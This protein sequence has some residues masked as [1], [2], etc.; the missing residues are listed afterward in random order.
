MTEAALARI[1]AGNLWALLTPM[2]NIIYKTIT[3]HSLNRFVHYLMF[4]FLH[5]ISFYL[6]LWLF[7]IPCSTAARR[8][9]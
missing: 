2:T 1:V 9:T 7:P 3:P 4:Y 5:Q 8:W 6:W